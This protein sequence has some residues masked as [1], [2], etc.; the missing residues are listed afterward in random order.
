MSRK[1]AVVL[2]LVG[3]VFGFLALG[4]SASDLS[5]SYGQSLSA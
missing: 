2:I 4:L 1:N 5:T 3:I